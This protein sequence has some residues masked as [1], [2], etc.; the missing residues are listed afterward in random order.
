MLIVVWKV[1]VEYRSYLSKDETKAKDEIKVK[2]A[3]TCKGLC[4]LFLNECIR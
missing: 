3:D 4:G 2:E 1:R